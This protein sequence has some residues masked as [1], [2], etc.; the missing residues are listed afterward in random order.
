MFQPKTRRCVY[1][2]IT[3][4]LACLL[5]GVWRQIA[6]ISPSSFNSAETM[7]TLRYATRAK[8][9]KTK[10]VVIMVRNIN[11]LVLTILPLYVMQLQLLNPSVTN[12]REDNCRL[13]SGGTWVVARDITSPHG[14]GG[15]RNMARTLWTFYLLRAMAVYLRLPRSGKLNEWGEGGCQPSTP[16]QPHPVLN[17]RKIYCFSWT[18][19]R[20]YK[21]FYDAWME[22]HELCVRV[23]LSR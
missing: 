13:M 12:S 8:R 23:Q 17:G 15:G 11:T 4:V 18:E 16:C 20:V 22:A 19:C 10:P 9:M 7:N 5:T 14:G 21:W 3:Y 6:C 1:A 2:S